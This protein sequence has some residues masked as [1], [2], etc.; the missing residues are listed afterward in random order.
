MSRPNGKGQCQVCVMEPPEAVSSETAK[1]V[2]SPASWTEKLRSIS[3]AVVRATGAALMDSGSSNAF[4]ASDAEGRDL[5]LDCSMTFVNVPWQSIVLDLM[6]DIT[7]PSPTHAI[8][9]S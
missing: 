5:E 1:E 6:S 4:N 3:S 2:D 9:F 8:G 7:P